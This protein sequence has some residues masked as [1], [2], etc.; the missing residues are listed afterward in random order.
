MAL[1]VALA[2]DTML[3]RSVAEELRRSPEPKTLVSAGVREAIAEADLFVLNL[4]CCVSDRGHRWPDPWKAFFFRAPPAAAKVL[5]ELGV[6]CVTLANNHALDYGFDA[7]AD[8]CTLLAGVGVHAV[9]AGANAG[10]A[11]EFAVLEAGG[12]RLAVVGVTDHPEDYAAGEDSPGVAWADLHAGVPGWLTKSVARAA[13]AA[14]VVLVTPHWGPNM[15]SRPPRRVSAAAPELLAAGAT[16]VAGHSAHVF[17][18]IADRILYDLGDFVDD[19]AVDPVL[20]NDLGL[21]FLVT[22][23]GPDAAH[24][25]PAQ[26]EAVPLAL[27][28]CH[29]RLAIG[30]D[31]EWIRERLTTACAEFG[32]AVADRTGRLTVDWR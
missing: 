15:T 31:R 29:T 6:N 32:T 23:D 2:G 11:R 27:D 1:T 20:R 28:Y 24:M 12:V 21:L 8:T 5:A 25:V 4:E 30:E 19:Y 26:V 9:G 22:L 10:A 14:D 16:L 13:A 18:G 7:M 17:H 3:G